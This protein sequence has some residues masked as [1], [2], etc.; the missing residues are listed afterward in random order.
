M[1]EF[2]DLLVEAL[3]KELTEGEVET[4]IRRITPKKLSE[5]KIALGVPNRFIKK[6]VEEK[7]IDSIR[8]TAEEMLGRK[9][10]LEVFVSEEDDRSRLE[11]KSVLDISSKI[12][13]PKYTFDTFVVG[14]GNQFA[15]AAALAVSNNPGKAYNPL[16]IYSGVGLG[17]THLLNAIG[18]N[19][20]RN[21]IITDLNKVR[22]VT[23]EAFVN[24]VINSIRYDKM[25]SFRSKYRMVDIL[26][27]DDIQFISGKERTQEEFFHTFNALYN[28]GKQI[29]ITSDKFPGELPGIEDRLKS[30][31]QW[32][33]IADIQP[34]DVETKVAIL[35]KKS[36]LENIDLDDEVAFF[37]ARTI[38]SNIRNLEGALTRL[39]AYAQLTG[40][41]I[42]VELAKELLKNMIREEPEVITVER[43]QKAVSSYFGV[44]ISDLRSSKRKKGITLPR[45]I[46]MYLA[47][48]HTDLSL[49]EIGEKFGGRNHATVTHSINK[50]KKLILTD[51]RIR[52]AVDSVSKMLT[53][54]L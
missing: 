23:T 31:F 42:T 11:R 53:K 35:K 28:L 19:V 47:R 39:Y 8:K 25:D 12:F 9:V 14:A 43:I 7:Y 50:V 5:S 26:L 13:N 18:H 3:K 45:Q 1:P 38:D 34:P 27:V 32:G 29:V 30:R 52:E 51:R 20:I 40:C 36:E 17:K 41:K 16:F 48:E 37:L 10:E 54:R 21:E 46:A 15:R 44:S 22:Y 6:W 24:E 2:W 49:V 33:L 4:W